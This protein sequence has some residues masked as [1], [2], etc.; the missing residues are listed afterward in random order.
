MAQT[1]AHLVDHAIPH[2]PVRQW[3]LSPTLERHLDRRLMAGS[4][5]GERLLTGIV[6]SNDRSRAPSS[7]NRLSSL[8]PVLPLDSPDSRPIS[9]QSSR[10]NHRTVLLSATAYAQS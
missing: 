4:V 1:A 8:D 2:G 5:G 10:L 9:D 7:A 3:V 6:N